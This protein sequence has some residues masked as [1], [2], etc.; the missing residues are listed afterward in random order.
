[1]GMHRGVALRNKLRGG[2]ETA[3]NLI[4]VSEKSRRT[5]FSETDQGCGTESQMKRPKSTK[6]EGQ[7]HQW[8]YDIIPHHVFIDTQRNT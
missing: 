7:L 4:I 8:Q 1:M 5:F 2:L 6:L 3:S